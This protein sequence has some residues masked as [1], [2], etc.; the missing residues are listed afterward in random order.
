MGPK[1]IQEKILTAMAR[2][3][4]FENYQVHFTDLG[5]LTNTNYRVCIHSTSYFVRMG[6]KYPEIF[7]TST[8]NDWQCTALATLLGLSPKS[9]LHFPE[10]RIIVSEFIHTDGKD[11][12]LHDPPIAKRFFTLLRKLHSANIQFPNQFCPYEIIMIY[13]QNAKNLGI[14]LPVEFAKQILPFINKMQSA[15]RFSLKKVPCHLDLHCQN[16][17]D[18]GKEFWLIDWEY[19]AMADPFIDLASIASADHFSDEQMEQF[20]QIYLEHPPSQE[21]IEHLYL[22]RILADARWSCFSYLHTKVTP[23]LKDTYKEFAEEFLVQCLERL[24]KF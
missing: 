8:E 15:S 17:L 21:E 2:V 7:G 20:L 9:F 3:A 13:V 12:H 19:A 23:A 22:M 4:D 16:V 24:R 18:D 6:T 5:G 11:I 1:K 10:D 14:S